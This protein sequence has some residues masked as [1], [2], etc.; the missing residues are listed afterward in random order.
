MYRTF[1]NNLTKAQKIGLVVVAQAL[2]I[3]V[4][5]LLVQSFT[6]EKNHVEIEKDSNSGMEIPKKAEE[7]VSEN[8][9]SIIKSRVADV[10]RNDINDAVIR[11]G[12][13]NETQNEDGSISA[14]FIVD[15]DSLK[16][17]FTVSTGWSEDE[18]E[19]YET[20][21]DCPRADQMKYPET[22]CYGAYHNTYSLG[23]YLPYAVYPEGY[24][25]EDADPVAPN[26]LI[27]GDEETKT[28]DIMVSTCN[29]EEYKKAALDYLKT[30]PIDFSNYTVNF[31]INN[32][33]VEC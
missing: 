7:F 8:I 12:S 3:V 29:V 32:I 28:L 13:Y 16:Q 31:E 14:S 25:G 10:T 30:I 21:I 26:Y 4:L 22:I 15:I 1:W 20:I 33:N 6:A 27:N 5:V 17:S 18:S 23:L 11:E 2:V 9:W 19:V 24:D